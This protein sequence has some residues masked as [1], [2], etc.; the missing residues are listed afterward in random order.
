MIQLHTFSFVDRHIC[1]FCC[2]QA[3]IWNSF[4]P[5]LAVCVHHCMCRA[6]T[7]THTYLHPPT[8]PHTHTHTHT[9][10]HPPTHPPTHPHTNRN[11]YIHTVTDTQELENFLNYYH[12]CGWAKFLIQLDHNKTTLTVFLIKIS[13]CISLADIS[14][15][16]PAGCN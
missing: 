15:N 13:M 9:Y 8:H 5:S 3:E 6:H 11:S 10:L 16:K 7:H 1:S 12:P 14:I 4:K 2:L